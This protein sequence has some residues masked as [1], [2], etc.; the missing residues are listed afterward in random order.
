MESE[1][2][3]SSLLMQNTLMNS[4]SAAHHQQQM[5][6]SSLSSSGSTAT[7]AM[8]LQEAC[9]KKESLWAWT[10]YVP[11]FVD[12]DVSISAHFCYFPKRWGIDTYRR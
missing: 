6:G 1:A 5:L 9:L 11:Q 3:V 4:S 8:M 2:Y 10:L 7:A 12:T